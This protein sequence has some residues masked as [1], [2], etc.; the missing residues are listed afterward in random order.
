MAG[1][2]LGVP[3]AIFDVRSGQSLQVPGNL[4]SPAA[5]G[6][7]L[8]LAL[9]VASGAAGL[10][11]ELLWTRRVLDLLGASAEA[12]SRVFGAF[13]LG[14][15]LGAGLAAWFGSRITRP[16]RAVALVEGG[17]VLLSLPALGVPVWSGGLWPLLGL[18]RAGSWQ[19]RGLQGLLSLML[20]V[21]PALCMGWFLPLICRAT[22]GN[23][24]GLGRLAVGL[25]A[26]NTAG[27]LLGLAIVA[28][29]LLPLAGVSGSMAA[30]MA[31]NALVACVAW[32]LQARTGDGV[33][34]PCPTP[35]MTGRGTAPG[36]RDLGPLAGP[37]AAAFVS[38]L[39]L[40]AFEVLS[41]QT[42]HLVAPLTFDAPAVILAGVILVLALAAGL[43]AAIPAA[44]LRERPWLPW[45][46]ALA[47][48]LMTLA[49]VWF[50]NRAVAAGGLPPQAS[51]GEFLY[52]LLSLTLSAFGPAL[53]AAGGVFPLAILWAED[54]ASGDRQRILGLLLAVN[55]VGGFLGAELAQRWLLPT[56]GVHGGTGMIGLGYG[57]AAI[58]VAVLARSGGGRLAWKIPA[59][60][61]MAGMAVTWAWL[62]PL[63]MVNPHMGL[64]VL[65]HRAG[66]DGT[67]A[68][69][70]HERFG[71]ALLVANQ[72]LLG[73]SG[74]RYDEERLGHLPL[75]LHPQP[76]QVAF[77]GMATG[78]TAGAALDHGAVEEVTVVELSPLVVDAAARHFAAFNHDLIRSPRVR[79][80]PED[81]RTVI[82]AAP[83]RFDVVV[84]DLFLP[85]APGA[86]RLFSREHFEAVRASLKPGGVY[87]QWLPMH[88]LTEAQW[89]RVLGTFQSVF[90][91]VWM[92]QGTYRSQAPSLALVG[93]AGAALD[94]KVIR[95]RCDQERTMG[96]LRDPLLRHAE[97]VAALYLG[98]GDSGE[99]PRKDITLGNAWLELDAGRLLMMGG[100][101]PPYLRGH[102][103]LAFLAS[104]ALH[105]GWGSG[106]P[107]PWPAAG[108]A[109]S[110]RTA[111][112]RGPLDREA[113]HRLI[114]PAIL[115]DPGADWTRWSG[116]PLRQPQPGAMR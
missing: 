29:L 63:P 76:K 103:W 25:Y 47:G 101:D 20:V 113:A 32:I 31:L 50:V 80:I 16:W 82:A 97:G 69:V 72:Y 66:R 38:G 93:Y 77:L 90:G 49:N 44:G 87:C 35:P 116:P 64:R 43:V 51:L 112:S 88:Q 46:L 115:E 56:F 74:V 94:W 1:G 24:D 70:E 39:G 4:R 79:V 28:G 34:V 15:A 42:L 48:L 61:G 19:W 18:E 12:Q 57:V 26:A 108:V 10:G 62:R 54:R 3:P 111:S 71:R 95:A 91:E 33:G 110:E 53:L 41:L 40:L 84:G 105:T 55:G 5:S 78:I 89:R 98:R 102:R 106:S 9:A 114:A 65:E 75:L 6:Y 60:A 14:L 67:L 68:V 45:T 92:F 86:G 85:W 8:A 59:V 7:L 36:L 100:S 17:V 11:H 83:G 2:T 21:P 52:R 30:M 27:G 13:F 37:L 23:R 104:R 73:S 99:L 96:G 22:L 58:G 109:L 81:C 107:G